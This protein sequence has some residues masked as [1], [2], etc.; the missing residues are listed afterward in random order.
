MNTQQIQNIIKEN[1]HGMFF[2]FLAAIIAI[3]IRN[4]QDVEVAFWITLVSIIVGGLI[5]YYWKVPKKFLDYKTVLTIIG[6]A[7]AIIL[8][9]R[10]TELFA[11]TAVKAG[12]LKA[13]FNAIVTKVP[14]LGAFGVVGAF[15]MPFSIFFGVI[16]LIIGLFVIGIPLGGLIST[17]SKNWTLMLIVIAIV[18]VF[19]FLMKRK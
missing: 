5:T 8:I 6:L 17:I 1:S 13:T 4:V 9:G 3:W 11:S 16:A 2:G 15:L 7:F 18:V 10:Q 12:F 19:G 14:F